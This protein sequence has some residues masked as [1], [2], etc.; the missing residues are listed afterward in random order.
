MNHTDKLY[1]IGE[2][3]KKSQ[4]PID[5]IRYYEKLKLVKMPIRS[6][7]GFRLYSEE[8]V[9]K[10]LFIK[11][12]KSFGLTLNEVHKITKCGDRGLEPCCTL[13]TKGFENKINE[14]EHKIKELQN[15][16]RRL[17]LLLSQWAKHE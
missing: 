14:F 5:T 12:A 16:K 6:E 10:L 15:S 4:T 17:K 1:Q 8:A 7:G 11:K 2:A 13:V 9:Q 3:A